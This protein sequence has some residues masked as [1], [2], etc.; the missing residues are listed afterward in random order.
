MQHRQRAIYVSDGREYPGQW[1][2]HSYS[3]PT[4]FTVKKSE[5][6]KTKADTDGWRPMT[7]YSVR[8]GPGL[9]SQVVFSGK[10]EVQLD[11]GDYYFRIESFDPP[12][13]NVSM[14]STS[15]PPVSNVKNQALNQ[16]KGQAVNVAM[17]LKER[18]ETIKGINDRLKWLVASVGAA[19]SGNLVKSANHLRR[20]W[21]S[22]T[23]GAVNKFRAANDKVGKPLAN[24]WLELNFLH[25]QVI[26]D[27]NGLLKELG[28]ELPVKG[29]FLHGRSGKD[30]G[31]SDIIKI[32]P[33]SWNSWGT[34]EFNRVQKCVVYAQVSAKPDV[35]FLSDASRLGLTNAPYVLWDS[36]P[37]SF[38]FDWVIPVGKYLNA[39]DAT[40]GMEFKGAHYGTILS[41]E[42][43]L[44]GVTQPEGKVLQTGTVSVQ[45][46]KWFAR[47]LTDWM[48]EMPKVQNPLSGLAWKAATTA[49]LLANVVKRSQNKPR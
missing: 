38:V 34:F 32:S 15:L 6:Q 29:G 43:K 27:A 46:P 42:L 21:R 7:K 35:K 20:F 25:M 47:E 18:K 1:Y 41:Q 45:N 14:S 26:A 40:L 3:D 2:E 44:I 11:Y 8:H 33:Y 28:E 48:P 17:M 12:P 13:M 37:L 39:W 4:P 23:P 24:M 10:F 5:V 16:L 9:Y 36:V 31:G 49:A 19:R 22:R 30:S